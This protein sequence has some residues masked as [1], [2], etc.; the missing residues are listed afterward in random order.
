MNTDAIEAL[1]LSTASTSTRTRGLRNKP[2][3]SIES[4]DEDDDEIQILTQIPTDNSSKPG[5]FGEKRTKLNPAVMKEEPVPLAIAPSEVPA[6]TSK[7]EVNGSLDT[8]GTVKVYCSPNN[9]EENSDVDVVNSDTGSGCPSP[10][11]L[12]EHSPNSSPGPG[13]G[14]KINNNNGK[15]YVLGQLFSFNNISCF[16]AK[17][18]V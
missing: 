16:L 4:S 6:S 14:I 3:Q 11:L 13:S 9:E 10:S 12:Q 2:Q 8:N 17:Y 15:S 18:H 5:D 1:Y 7:S